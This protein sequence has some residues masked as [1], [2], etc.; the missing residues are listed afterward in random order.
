MEVSDDE[1]KKINETQR[2]KILQYVAEKY[3]KPEEF[4]SPYWYMLKNGKR[5]I[6]DSALKVLLKYLSYDEYVK[7][8]SSEPIYPIV[9]DSLTNA[10]IYIDT[11]V[12]GVSKILEKYPE[13]ETYFSSKVMPLFSKTERKITVTE[14][15]LRKF[16][17]IMKAKGRKE[18]ELRAEGG[19]GLYGRYAADERMKRTLFYATLA[20]EEAFNIYESTSKRVTTELKRAVW[21]EEV[22][23]SLLKRARYV[24][25]LVALRRLAEEEERA[26]EDALRI[27]R[28]RLNEYI[29]KYDLRSFLNVDEDIARRLADAKATE[30]SKFNNTNF[31]VKAYA[32]LLV[33][34]DYAVGRRSAYGTIARYWLKEGGA[35]RLLYYAPNTAYNKAERTKV[36]EPLRS[37]RL[38]PRPSVA[39]S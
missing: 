20:L 26:F 31:G 14:E 39:C 25:D 22:D 9:P 37:R 16:E 19:V 30:F 5:L 24:V 8:L 6:S 38:S 1:L 18:R 2:K 36:E 28:K 10:I 34:R 32:A 13:L 4:S 27:L 17:I 23:V 12:N 3:G 11:F 21:K 15:H 33:Y 29:V 35:A 7:L